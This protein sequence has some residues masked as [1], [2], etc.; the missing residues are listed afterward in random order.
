LGAAYASVRQFT[1]A[2]SVQQEAIVLLQDEKQK[3][4][5]TS[6][7]ELYQAGI[8]YRDSA[9]LEQQA[10]AFHDQGR[11]AEAEIV[12]Q[13]LLPV[14]RKLS[15]DDPQ[16]AATLAGLTQTLLAG[17]KFTEAEQPAREC[18]TIRE[19][20][21]PDDWLTFNARNLLGGSLLGQKKYAEAEPIL[22]SSYEGMKQREG[23]IPS[24]GKA[25]V[26]ENLRRLV[27]LYEATGQSEKTVEWNRNLAAFDGAEAGKNTAAPKP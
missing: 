3:K 24:A 1:N 12:Y 20:Q 17:Q 13:E 27:Q 4:D 25:R 7:L 21:L 10:R 22:L 8:P 9:T 23:K 5:Y 16:L 26:K 15:A 2:V 18:L 14:R 11:L 19:K 6:R